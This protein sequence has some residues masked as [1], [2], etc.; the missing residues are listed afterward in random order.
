MTMLT[1]PAALFG[2]AFAALLL[3]APVCA[4]SGGI[5][6]RWSG[7][8]PVSPGALLEITVD[9]GNVDIRRSDSSQVELNGT[10]YNVERIDFGVIPWTAPAADRISVYARINPQFASRAAAVVDIAVPDGIRLNVEIVNGNI[11]MVGVATADAVLKTGNGAIRVENATGFLTLETQNGK[12]VVNGLEGAI[13]AR[14]DVGPIRI[15]GVLLPGH[16]SRIRTN[17]GDVD[18][19]LDGVANIR[20]RGAT[21]NGR[22]TATGIPGVEVTRPAEPGATGWEFS[23]TLGDGAASLEIDVRNGS[24]RVRIKP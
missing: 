13:D 11:T 12:I 4:T 5:I 20:L 17:D 23:G 7:V 19:T 8:F 18:V 3:L 1:R 15:V 24:I 14:A 9:V 2:A 22:I 10:L 16:A 6:N 21:E